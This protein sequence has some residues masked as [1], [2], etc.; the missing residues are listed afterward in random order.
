MNLETI[1][2]N[3]FDEVHKTFLVESE[4]YKPHFYKARNELQ[5][6]IFQIGWIFI[7]FTSGPVVF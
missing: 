4:T 2:Q 7:Q 5:N 3:V 6:L 1:T